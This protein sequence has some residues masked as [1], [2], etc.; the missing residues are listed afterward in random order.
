MDKR[1][2]FIFGCSGHGKVIAELAEMLKLKIHAI[3]DDN[4][5]RKHFGQIPIYN[6][7]EKLSLNANS[8]II[9]GVGNNKI[10]KMLS[11][12]FNCYNLF[13]LI[14]SSAIVSN[15]AKIENGT[16]IMANVIVNAEA[17]IGKHVILNS[18]S[19]IEHNCIIEDFAH[20]SPGVTLSG[21]ILIGE[22]THIGSGA[23]VIPGVK[24]GK[25]CT[26]GAGTIVLQDIPDGA[27]VVG[28]PGRIVKLDHNYDILKYEKIVDLG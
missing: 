12:R 17:Q 28:N 26:I 20:I 21:N 11:K 18:A 7:S 6:T 1:K 25:W 13:T 4:P 14:H 8:Y 15:S 2:N 10:R 9:I 27:T 16:V 22:G 3:L 19:I 24:I 23:T 5:K